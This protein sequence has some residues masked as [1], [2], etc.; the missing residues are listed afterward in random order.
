MKEPFVKPREAIKYN[1]LTEE[2]QKFIIEGL[3]DM[4]RT[5]NE[6]G[7]EIS[8]MNVKNNDI[9]IR[10]DANKEELKVMVDE[11]NVWRNLSFNQVLN[12]HML[13]REHS[14]E[15]EFEPIMKAFNKELTVTDK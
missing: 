7:T 5:F 10:K 14:T 12:F 6:L 1:V 13:V 3:D 11:M 4:I 8:S 2:K 9:L 15:T